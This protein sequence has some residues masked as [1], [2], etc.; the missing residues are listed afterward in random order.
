MEV[1]GGR[2]ADGD[3]VQPCGGS[4]FD[5]SAKDTHVGGKSVWIGFGRSGSPWR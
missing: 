3:V 5:C 4:L 1:D 2:D